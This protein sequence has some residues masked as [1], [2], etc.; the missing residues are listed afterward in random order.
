MGLDT[1]E[2]AIR[3]TLVA[4]ART[5]NREQAILSYRELG[6]EWDPNHTQGGTTPGSRPP[7]RG[8]PLALGNILRHEHAAGRPLLTSIV[9]TERTGLPGNRFADLA[10]DLG[11]TVP[12][13]EEAWWFAEV[14]KT[15]SYWSAET[16]ERRKG[17]LAELTS[18]AV[19]AAMDDYDQLGRDAFLHK[20]GFGE[21]KGLFVVRDDKQY[22]SKAIA[23]AAMGHLA[24]RSAWTSNDFSGGLGTVVPVLEGLGFEVV[25]TRA[26]RNP[27][28][29]TEEIILALDVY[30]EHGLLDDLDPRVQ[31]LSEDLNALDIHEQRPDEERW[32]NPNGAA[33]KLANFAHFDPGYPGKGMDAASKLDRA[34]FERLSPYPD[35]VA[36]L[37]DEVRAGQ[38]IALDSLPAGADASI[39]PASEPAPST[40]VT[41]VFGDVEQSHTTGKF[42]VRQTAEDREAERIEQPLVLRFC[43]FLDEMGYRY[44]R[45]TYRL[46]GIDYP[47]DLV[48]PDV[49]LLVE[50]KSK[51]TRSYLRM[52]VGQVKDYEFMHAE[53]NGQVFASWAILLRG[54]PA[55][56]GVR[57][58]QREGLGAIWAVE[59]GWSAT[60][61][62]MKQLDKCDWVSS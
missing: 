35:L 38:R 58:L 61:D 8:L 10:R 50:A 32:R 54:R 12:D 6:L 34:L 28:W 4:R 29:V 53:E 45:R 51:V 31:K 49:G 11:V 48:L 60:Q 16:R 42:T 33:L 47:C 1:T 37:A 18:E 41:S 3:T 15:L 46:D 17:R 20:Y 27:R 14:E 56:S 19:N 23:G 44:G 40:P 30:L 36:R 22:D 26:K 39:T 13:D 21:A 25:D 59:D 57:Y 62:V 55:D 7:F 43:S 24:N 9:V 2:E 5:G 52:A